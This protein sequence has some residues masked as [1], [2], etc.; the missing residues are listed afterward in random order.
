MADTFLPTTK[1][2]TKPKRVKGARITFTEI[3]SEIGKIPDK[4][5]E[6]TYNFVHDKHWNNGLYW[7]GWRPEPDKNGAFS[8]AAQRQWKYVCDS[9][10]FQND[11]GTNLK[12]LEGAILGNEPDFDIVSAKDKPLEDPALEAKR[13]KTTDEKYF[14]DIDDKI[15]NW[16][17][18]KGIHQALKD[19]LSNR[20]S[21]GKTAMLVYIPEGYLQERTLETDG[22][23]KTEIVLPNIEKF[24]DVLPKICVEV[25]DYKNVIDVKDAE[26][27]GKFSIIRLNKDANEL[28]RFG[29][30]Y[31]DVDGRSYFR[32]VSQKDIAEGQGSSV[33]CD[34]AGNNLCI[35]VGEYDKALITASVKSEQKA[36]NH[37]VT[38]EQFALANINYPE[39]T[40]INAQPFEETNEQGHPTGKVTQPVAGLGIFRFLNGLKFWD[41]K[42]GEQVASPSIHQRDGAD[43]EKFAKVAENKS[44]AIARG[45]GMGYIFLSD[46][47]YASGDSKIE[48]MDDYEIL[49]LDYETTMNTVGT[50]LLETVVR[51]AFN[52]TNQTSR[53]KD[54]NVIFRV[55]VS[56]GAITNDDKRVMMEECD[57]GLRSD[58]NYMMKAKVSDNPKTEI[59]RIA[60]QP[61]KQLNGNGTTPK[62]ELTKGAGAK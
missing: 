51:L 22:E 8:E 15:V 56:T 52:F 25:I 21:Y 28:D 45:M 47:E 62:P 42:G 11:I 55:N 44:K 14:D 2:T 4:V 35:T 61:P 13:E 32:V 1:P 31:V 54:F 10:T 19:F 48:S 23:K 33:S 37:A 41:D 46:S 12:R 18:Q 7:I 26:F 17:T 50:Q 24:E 58:E 36:L 43:P 3:Q 9:F 60:A 30:F 34:L 29:V 5:L 27:G 39:T 16:W 49:L 20:A 59:Q 57:K 53:N 40:F 6:E 38:G